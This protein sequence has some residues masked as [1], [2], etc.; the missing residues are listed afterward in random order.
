[1]PS[2]E[3]NR[4]IAIQRGE[5]GRQQRPPLLPGGIVG[6]VAIAPEAR[7]HERLEGGRLAGLAVMV[8]AAS[9]AA[10][11]APVDRVA[12]VAAPV[13]VTPAN[14]NGELGVSDVPFTLPL[15]LDL[16]A[17]PDVDEV[18]VRVDLPGRL[19]AAALAGQ[20]ARLDACGGQYLP[21][22]RGDQLHRA[23][24]DLAVGHVA[25]GLLSAPLHEPHRFVHQP[26][27]SAL[28]RRQSHDRGVRRSVVAFA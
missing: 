13:A 26:V 11:R 1:M 8:G 20:Q 15:P 5:R 23:Q 16:R 17:G 7:D 28:H 27:I 24:V 12:A 19:A 3:L 6:E 21:P 22:R 14:R 9:S 25:S 4:L 18:G 2:E 10:T